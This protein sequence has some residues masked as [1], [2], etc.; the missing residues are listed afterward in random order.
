M[1]YRNAIICTNGHVISAISTTGDNSNCKYCTDC[2]EATLTTCKHCNSYIQ[3]LYFSPGVVYGKRSFD[4][5]SF[6]HNCGKAYPW[7]I[8]KLKAI[9]ELLFIDQSL[10]QAEAETLA[11]DLDSL[12]ID[13]PKT[14]VIATK[15]KLAFPKLDPAIKGVLRDLL[16]DISSETAKKILMPES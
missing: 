12:M 15:M 10:S 8:E 5:P 3:G 4:A 13:I 1:S 2:G 7:T 6:C 9:E 16:V 11:K 14:K